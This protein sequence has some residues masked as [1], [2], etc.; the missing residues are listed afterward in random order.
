MF[1]WSE[2]I[3]G[4]KYRTKKYFDGMLN[5][6]KFYHSNCNS[7][8]IIFSF[9]LNSWIKKPQNDIFGEKVQ[10]KLVELVGPIQFCRSDTKD[11]VLVYLVL[12]ISNILQDRFHFSDLV[13]QIWFGN[14]GQQ[15]WFI[16]RK[17]IFVDT[18]ST[19]KNYS[20]DQRLAKLINDRLKNR[21]LPEEFAR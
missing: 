11:L 18:V 9:P 1:V 8:N 2:R 7:E 16:S 13:W 19:N 17:R 15:I 14:L 20:V 5:P 12:Y 10:L 4:S 3:F 21:I 6:L